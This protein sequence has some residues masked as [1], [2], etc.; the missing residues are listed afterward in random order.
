M[1]LNKI[2]EKISPLFRRNRL[3][4]FIEIM[5][6][7]S[8]TR[9]LDVGGYPWF[10]KEPGF[11]IESKFTI[12]NLEISAAAERYRNAQ[13]DMVVGDG[14][15]LN[16]ADGEFDIVFSNSVIEHLGSE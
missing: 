12:L 16:Y 1:N 6:P 13:F 7:T 14:T 3:R 4:R 2:Y 5:A 8:E 9:I 15:C 10:W 11:V